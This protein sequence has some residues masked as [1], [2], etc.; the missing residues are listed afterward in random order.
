MKNKFCPLS[1]LFMTIL[2]FNAAAQITISKQFNNVSNEKQVTNPLK[3]SDHSLVINKSKQPEIK[4]IYSGN[5]DKALTGSVVCID[6]VYLPGTTM[7]ITFHLSIYSPDWEYGNGF[8]LLFPPGFTI[9][10][11]DPVPIS[12]GGYATPAIFAD[13]VIWSTSFYFSSSS[14]GPLYEFD[15]DVNVSIASVVSGTQLGSYYVW[16]DGYG[17][18][19]H[20]YSGT[21]NMH[22]AALPPAND[23]CHHAV[24]IYC[25]DTITG[26]T[27]GAT[28]DSNAIDCYTNYSSPGVWYSFTGNGQWID[29][30]ICSYFNYDSKMFVYTGTCG[31]YTCVAGNDDFCGLGSGVGFL[32]DQGTDYFIVV[33]G[34]GGETGDFE[35]ALNCKD[36]CLLNQPVDIQS[37]M[38]D[39]TISIIGLNNFQSIDVELLHET[40]LFAGTPTHT[41]IINPLYIDNLIPD[42]NYHFKVR[43]ECSPGQFSEW[44]GPYKFNTYCLKYINSMQLFNDGIVSYA[45]GADT[46]QIAEDFNIPPDE[47]WEITDFTVSYFVDNLDTMN[48]AIYSNSSSDLP[49][50]LLHDDIS[51]NFDSTYVGIF[52]GMKTYII[53]VTLNPAFQL[54]GG[55]TGATYWLSTWIESDGNSCYWEFS[56]N[57]VGLEP[58]FRDISQLFTTCHNWET[59]ST[60]TSLQN[61]SMSLSI[62]FKDIIPPVFDNCPSDT[63][64]YTQSSA[65]TV[66]HFSDPIASDNCLVTITQTDGL[67]SGSIFPVGSTTN[68]FEADDGSGNTILCEFFVTVVDNTT[69]DEVDTKLFE[70]YPN[71]TNGRFAISFTDFS[72]YVILIFTPEGSLVYQQENKN[73]VISDDINIQHLNPGI[74]YL[75]VIL[76]N[77]TSVQKILVQ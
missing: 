73:P 19:P 74:Y 46:V 47:C 68:V 51:V 48:F 10:S 52:N 71:P 17:S 36:T 24:Q 59:L 60:C 34:Y 11:A 12:S 41:G 62:N 56:N 42:T 66:V 33:S 57:Q 26:T 8:Y 5:S 22:S 14:G 54:C 50:N 65:G 53:T 25:G 64:I 67:P 23:S 29:A 1:L 20:N 58:A 6:S 40:Q 18:S 39:V 30:D 2:V 55:L 28:L 43:I 35:L 45:H 38:T 3:I 37:T 69:I 49:G 31:N 32:S 63:T 70:I 16:G 13:S 9:N 77:K 7:N 72:P 27:I 76:N 61:T 4:S 15:F 75:H 21:F 44:Q